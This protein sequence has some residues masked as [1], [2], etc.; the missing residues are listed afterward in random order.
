MGQPIEG[1]W[2]LSFPLE[3]LQE[4]TIALEEKLNRQVIREITLTA[5]SLKTHAQFEDPDYP[6][7]NGFPLT[8]YL[9]DGS[10]CL[11]Y[12]SDAADDR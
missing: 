5:T 6:T 3:L 7:C 12:T 11:L 4:R 9:T 8:V 10:T 1:E 2:T